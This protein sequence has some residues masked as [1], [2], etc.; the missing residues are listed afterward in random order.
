MQ[1]SKGISPEKLK[2][3]DLN[4]C[5]IQDFLLWLEGVRNYSIASRNQRLAAIHS[6]FRYVIFLHPELILMCQQVLEIPYGRV[7]QKAIHFLTEEQMK[8]LLA[9]PD[10]SSRTGL[11]DAALLSLLYD[12]AARV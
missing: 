1:H 8:Q 4:V 7:P 3:D 9:Q 10:I 2:L 5:C 11:R 12:S 6:F